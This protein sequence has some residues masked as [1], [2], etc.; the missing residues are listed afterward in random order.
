MREQRTLRSDEGFGLLLGDFSVRGFEASLSSRRNGGYN[1]ARIHDP[2]LRIE[3]KAFA[4]EWVYL[5][6]QRDE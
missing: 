6:N 3:G 5:S 1:W 2:L 4:A